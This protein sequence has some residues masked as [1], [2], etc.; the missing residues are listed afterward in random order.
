MAGK[1]GEAAGKPT[2]PP[3]SSAA[4][5]QGGR[6]P[7]PSPPRRFPLAGVRA[8]PVI[9]VRAPGPPNTPLAAIGGGARARPV[10]DVRAPSR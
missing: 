6:A 2:P 4:S 7:F 8:R 9:D 1:P 3:S 10:I 5:P